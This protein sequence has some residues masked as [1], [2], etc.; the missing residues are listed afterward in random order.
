MSGNYVTGKRRG[1][2]DGVDF[3]GTGKVRFLQQD[4]I[5]GQLEQNHIVMLNSLAY[6]A[7]GEG[8]LLRHCYCTEWPLGRIRAA[9]WGSAGT[10][11]VTCASLERFT[12]SQSQVLDPIIIVQTGTNP[13]CHEARREPLCTGRGDPGIAVNL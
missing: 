5:R 1:V 4:A 12:R 6:S 7:S 11:A 3:Q 9:L 2:V 10:H 13:S 8:L